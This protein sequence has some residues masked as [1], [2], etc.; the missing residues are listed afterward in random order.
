V[1]F[2]ARFWIASTTDNA[3][4]RTLAWGSGFVATGHFNP[5]EEIIRHSDG[6]PI[7]LG[8]IRSL[9]LAQGYI[10]VAAG[11][12]PMFIADQ[13]GL[14]DLGEIP[15]GHRLGLGEL[16]AYKLSYVLPEL[17][18]LWSIGALFSSRRQRLLAVAAW[19][20]TPLMY[21]T[22]GQGMPDTWTIAIVLLA[23]VGLR[24]CERAESTR[25]AVRD[26]L[27]TATVIAAGSWGTKLVPLVLLVPLVALIARDK[28]FENSTR[29]RLLG[30]AAGLQFLF[31]LPY[32]LSAHLQANVL[33]RFEFDMLF[34]QNGISTAS[35]L[36]AAQFGLIAL[37]ALTGWLLASSNPWPRVE[38][39]VIGTML[40][41]TTTSGLITHLMCWA[42]IAIILL[43]GHDERSALAAQIA[44]GLAVAWHLL[45]YDW[46]SGFLV[47]AVSR[48]YSP[49][50]T[51]SWLRGHIPGLNVAGSA[52]ASAL[53]LAVIVAG[54][55]KFVPS[56]HAASTQRVRIRTMASLGLATLAI[57]TFAMITAAVVAIA[58]GTPTWD[59]GYASTPTSQRFYLT[60]EKGYE[61][62]PITS[63]EPISSAT[64]RIAT[65]TQPS[66]DDIRVRLIRND[67]TLATATMPVWQA[68]PLSD[69]GPVTFDFDR[70]VQPLGSRLVI[71][72]VSG[73]EPTTAILALEAVATMDGEIRP[74]A[75]LRSSKSASF[76]PALARHLT[77]P[78]RLL[79][80]PLLA[81]LVAA[82]V[83]AL[84]ARW[85]S[86][87]TQGEDAPTEPITKRKQERVPL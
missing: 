70:S 69:R 25:D 53:V 54:A 50:A 72:R 84:L 19:A 23:M 48:S 4:A 46:L 7:P 10:G 65:D 28:R 71:D 36:H 12:V 11:A 74:A 3:D 9:S 52:V 5:Y 68:E 27:I 59:L 41:V 6:D 24:R 83:E 8:G 81:A 64:L 45:T 29:I 13:L 55:R 66:L 21:F 47:F 43:I 20:T 62:S 33:V 18:I 60:D 42:V 14:I 22:W 80:V 79:A 73:D 34:S 75:A 26:Y 15:D 78:S 76:N 85:W 49:G 40:L 63:T 56:L 61:S 16:F 86:N 17:M 51:Y 1:G 38:P 39:W 35:A 31:A 30:A 37:I 67:M 58:D 57:S 82:A 87:T 32:L 77:S 2:G 44:F